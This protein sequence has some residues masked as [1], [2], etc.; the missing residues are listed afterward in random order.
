MMDAARVTDRQTHRTLPFGQRAALAAGKRNPIGFTLIELLVVIAIIALLVSILLPGL[1][2]AKA[3]AR[4]VTC[5]A[6][7]RVLGMALQ[8]YCAEQNQQFPVAPNGF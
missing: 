2:Q 6:N 7:Q 5:S 1:S 3:L 8:M 4:R